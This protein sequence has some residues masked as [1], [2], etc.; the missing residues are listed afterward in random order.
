MSENKEQGS[1]SLNDMNDFQSSGDGGQAKVKQRK[2]K[3]KEQDWKSNESAGNLLAGILGESEAEAEAERK[4]RDAERKAKEAAEEAERQATE[5]KRKAEADARLRAEQN[6]LAEVEVRR[7]QMLAAIERQKKIEKGE[8][9]LEEEARKKKEEDDR[10]RREAEAKAAKEAEFNRAQMLIQK[11]QEQ[12]KEMADRQ[13]EAAAL[14]PKSNTGLYI[15]IAAVVVVLGGV[16]AA[17][18]LT[19]EP[20]AELPNPYALAAQYPATTIALNMP[21]SDMN[22]VGLDVVSQSAGQA[23]V[24]IESTGTSSGG[25]KGSGREK[26]PKDSFQ[27]ALDS[28]AGGDVLKSKTKVVF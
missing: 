28:S 21:E 3:V 6:R 26:R 17:L 16:A 5:A 27:K 7:T 12:L 1:A 14:T 19:G 10:L 23:V 13:L 25:K 15:G 18:L 2:S 8:I 24:Q 11:Q 22:D 20:P 9:D 4:R